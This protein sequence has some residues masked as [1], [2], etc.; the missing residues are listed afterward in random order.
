MSKHHDVNIEIALLGLSLLETRATN[1][2]LQ[3]LSAEDFSDEKHVK[4][5]EVLKKIVSN[6]EK[7]DTNILISYL[8]KNDLLKFFNEGKY[9]HYL[10]A[11]AGYY[12]SI[13]YYL[14]QISE[15]SNLRKLEVITKE[16]LKNLNKD[17][18]YEEVVTIFQNQILN[19][20]NKRE[21]KTFVQIKDM[22]GEI[23]LKIAQKL[24]NNQNNGLLSGFSDLDDM[25]HG[26]QNGDLIIIAARPSMGKTAFALNIAANIAKRK[27]VAF[28]SLEMPTEQLI[29]RIISIFSNIDGNKLKKVSEMKDSDWAKLY[30]SQEIIAKLKLFIDDSPSLKLEELIWKSRK[31][32]KEGNLDIIIIDYLQLI[33]TSQNSYGNENRQQE[34]SKISRSLKQLARELEVPIIAL[35]Q[36]SRRV[37]QREDKT[38]LMSDLRESG[39]IEQDA[40]IIAFLYREDYYNKNN[41]EFNEIQETSIIISKHRNGA[42]GRINLLFSPSKGQ[43]SDK[44]N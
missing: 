28:F 10:I 31:L 32:K 9:L 3:Y 33:P 27:K 21:V 20:E 7:I 41:E 17:I 14:N 44:K 16:T 22:I 5:F 26:F 15:K 42:I 29:T 30:S 12:A 35:S 43:F 39:A 25:T 4:L 34:V 40:D 24:E 37:E 13:D 38:P 6:D 18:N 19:I 2:M 23:I 11:N 8:E 36:L 1:K